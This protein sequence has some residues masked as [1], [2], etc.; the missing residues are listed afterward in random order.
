M[1][2]CDIELALAKYFNYRIHLIVPNVF[3]GL[4]FNY[5]LDLMVVSAN[6]YATEIE[7]KTSVS[8]IKAE[9]KK[10]KSAHCSNKIKKFYFAV[11]EALKD[12][13]LELIP[14]KAGLFIV[15]PRLKVSIARVPQLNKAA[16][17]LTE[18][19]LKKLHELAA[20]RIWSLK[21]ALLKKAKKL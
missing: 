20:M 7:I 1:N 17:P 19:E 18:Q 8:D 12:K 6:N 21:E 13:A 3:W 10:R 14:E 15:S 2:A 9:S 16:R 5:E 4:G 11:P